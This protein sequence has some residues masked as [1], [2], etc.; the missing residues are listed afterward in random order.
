MKKLISLVVCMFCLAS[1]AA[2]NP[3]KGDGENVLTISVFNGG[4]NVQWINVLKKRFENENEGI[5]VK[6]VE[7]I[8]NTG[9]QRQITEL[10]S[11]ASKTDIYF[12]S[13]DIYYLI[14]DAK[15]EVNGVK[16]HLY[17]R[18]SEATAITGF[19]YLKNLKA[20]FKGCTKLTD[21]DKIPDPCKSDE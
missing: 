11:G 19:A 14:D 2:C 13:N 9:R 10:Q 15:I 17:E 21:Y 6:I 1:C 18:T 3:N 16:Y 5:T 12:C 4:Y 8:G 20:M 7:A